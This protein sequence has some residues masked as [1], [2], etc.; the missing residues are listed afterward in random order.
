MKFNQE[1]DLGVSFV[2]KLRDIG[3]ET[4]Q[5]V[6]LGTY[7]PGTPRAD[8]VARRG[9]D[10]Y[11]FELK[12]S[13]NAVLRRQILRGYRYFNFNYVVVP[14][15]KRI[16]F[17]KKHNVGVIVFDP[18]TFN[19]ESVR[20]HPER[21]TLQTRTM[22]T[23]LSWLFDDQKECIAGSRNG[24]ITP[25]SRSVDRIK[26]YLLQH[27]DA[28][29]KDLWDNLDLHWASLASFRSCLTNRR[30]IPVIDEIKRMLK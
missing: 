4:W 6:L 5:E 30:R 13:N 17:Y 1:T 23:T 14:S 16:T 8:V 22:N 2:E 28:T 25:F 19:W 27:P 15:I 10:L 24:V 11:R 29:V 20:F 12:L 7:A 18:E 9:K 3:F 26:E 21:K